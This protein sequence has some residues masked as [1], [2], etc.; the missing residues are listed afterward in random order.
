MRL[1]L[2]L[3]RAISC[4]QLELPEISA[5]YLVLC[6]C[7]KLKLNLEKRRKKRFSDTPIASITTPIRWSQFL[8]SNLDLGNI[9]VWGAFSSSLFSSV[10]D[11]HKDIPHNI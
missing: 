7:S 3:L 10:V 2:L 5:S 4:S 9:T 8:P 11:N 1:E 6:V